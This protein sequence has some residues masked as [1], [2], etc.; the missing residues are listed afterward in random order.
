MVNNNVSHKWCL[1]GL[2]NGVKFKRKIPFQKTRS[3]LNYEKTESQ[4]NHIKDPL[5][6]R[7]KEIPAI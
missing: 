4:K 1:T 2:E 5:K 6:A 3:Q 7:T